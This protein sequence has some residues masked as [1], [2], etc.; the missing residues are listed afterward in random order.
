[1]RQVPA[2]L[3]GRPRQSGLRSSGVAPTAVIC[4][5]P[6]DRLLLTLQPTRCHGGTRQLHSSMCLRAEVGTNTLVQMISAK[7]HALAGCTNK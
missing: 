4:V 7:S 1:M 3:P 5:H 6:R 2:H